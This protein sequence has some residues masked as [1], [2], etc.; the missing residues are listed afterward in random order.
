V[1]EGHMLALAKSD[2]GILTLA[3]ERNA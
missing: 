3:L 2:G 1:P